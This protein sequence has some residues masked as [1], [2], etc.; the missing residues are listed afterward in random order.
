LYASY[1]RFAGR[2]E[3][4][5]ILSIGSEPELLLLR[6]RVLENAGHSVVTVSNLDYAVAVFNSASFNGVIFCHR[7]PGAV[8]DA[9]VREMMST[10]SAPVFVFQKPVA[11]GADASLKLLG[12]K[13]ASSE[14]L[15]HELLA[16]FRLERGHTRH[17]LQSWK[18][19]AMYVGRGV[20]TVQR[21]EHLGLPV[22]R[23]G[24]GDRSAVFVLVAELEHWMTTQ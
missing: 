13:S 2:L 23:P 9:I 21:W 5:L 1:P 22:H 10:R 19:V 4:A 6:T 24:N 7:L 11:P 8:R 14:A 18:E 16:L 12:G 20:R 17:S 3:V 15:C